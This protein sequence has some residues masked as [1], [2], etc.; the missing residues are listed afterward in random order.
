MD[1]FFLAVVFD[2]L[3]YGKQ[4]VFENRFS[5]KFPE[6][7]Q[8]DLGLWGIR[9]CFNIEHIHDVLLAI[10]NIADYLFVY[11]NGGCFN[12]KEVKVI[13]SSGLGDCCFKPA[14]NY[15]HFFF[16]GGLTFY[17]W[18]CLWS[19]R[20]CNLVSWQSTLRGTLE[21][22]LPRFG[23]CLGSEH[24]T[25]HFLIQFLPKSFLFQLLVS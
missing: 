20:G 8:W 17:E 6:L 4:R 14:V 18:W 9:G 16:H 1:F 22:T 19:L 11:K 15:L 7:V 12:D 13:W 3:K 23:E 24:S 2:G 21:E 25:N 5:K 10:V